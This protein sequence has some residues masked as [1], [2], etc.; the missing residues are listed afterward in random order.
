MTYAG[1]L[2]KV[3]KNKIILCAFFSQKS[4][5][6]SAYICYYIITGNG[7]H[8]KEKRLSNMTKIYTNS[9]MT[10]KIRIYERSYTVIINGMYVYNAPTVKEAY[11]KALTAYRTLHI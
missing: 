8:Q 3:Y 11:K 6:I 2:C 7:K 4:V 5:D 9:D 1:S 10:I